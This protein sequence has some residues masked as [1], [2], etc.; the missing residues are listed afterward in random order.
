MRIVSGSF[1]GRKIKFLK[2]KTTRPLKDSVKEN[3]FNILNHSSKFETRVKNANILDLYS[4]VGSFG[5]ECISLG[6]KKTTFIEQD[7]KA[8]KIIEENCI[9]LSILK[10]TKI[11]TDKVENFLQ[12]NF[13]NKYDIFFFDPPYSNCDFFEDLNIIKKKKIYSKKNIVIIHRD[14][15]T[16]E[17]FDNY[18]KILLS[19]QYGR[20]RIIFGSFF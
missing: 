2:A 3:I 1:K 13:N 9:N 17:N 20:S 7:I 11:I 6:A 14:K 12:G 5:L 15:K 4:G 16:K 18:F 19:R 10:K 8:S